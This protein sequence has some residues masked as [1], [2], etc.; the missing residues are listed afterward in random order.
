MEIP[1]EIR[2]EFFLIFLGLIFLVFPLWL[3]FGH[4]DIFQQMV[5]N[6]LSSIMFTLISTS[7]VVLFL[8]GARE[9]TDNYTMDKDIFV[10]K[11][12]LER[13]N[14]DLKLKKLPEEYLKRIKFPEKTKKKKRK[15]LSWRKEQL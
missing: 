15:K 11:Y 14:I 4:P 8:Y 9:L 1:K 3:Y 7:G 13:Y 12:R 10:R 2:F 6:L 5:G